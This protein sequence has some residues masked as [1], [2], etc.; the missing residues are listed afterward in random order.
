M[1]NA[2]YKVV[3]PKPS[4]FNLI[5]SLDLSSNLYKIQGK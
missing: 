3:F 1:Y 4:N 5:K 2:T